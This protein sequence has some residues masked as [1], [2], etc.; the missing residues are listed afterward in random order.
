MVCR[1]VR[2]EE[3]MP[4]LGLVPTGVAFI[5]ICNCQSGRI[6]SIIVNGVFFGS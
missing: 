3:G 6:D 2:M 1:E 5:I 4:V